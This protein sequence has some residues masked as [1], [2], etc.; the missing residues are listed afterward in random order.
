MPDI[1]F[2]LMIVLDAYLMNYFI[3]FSELVGLASLSFGYRQLLLACILKQR[4]YIVRDHWELV[5]DAYF[6]DKSWPASCSLPPSYGKCIQI[7]MAR[8]GD[9]LIG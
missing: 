1:S 5:L 4:I 6:G 7:N 3:D 9:A 8:I 2:P